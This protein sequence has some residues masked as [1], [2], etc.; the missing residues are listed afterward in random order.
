ML[1]QLE[2]YGELQH[3]TVR[4]TKIDKVIFRMIK[5]S[6]I[7]WKDHCPLKMRLHKL[8]V[9][10]K[11]IGAYASATGSEHSSSDPSKEIPPGTLQDCA[12]I[13]IRL[14]H[15]LLATFSL[16]LEWFATSKLVSSWKGAEGSEINADLT[17]VELAQLYQ[18]AAELEIPTLISLVADTLLM[19]PIYK[20]MMKDLIEYIISQTTPNSDLRKLL[21][22]AVAG[23]ATSEAF[24]QAVNEDWMSKEILSELTLALVQERGGRPRKWKGGHLI[25]EEAVEA[26]QEF[27]I[28]EEKKEEMC[29]PAPAS[30]KRSASMGADGPT[31]KKRKA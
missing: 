28:H 10:Y 21:V 9:L 14:P 11:T 24:K 22:R 8:L 17:V 23:N 16:L 5:S 13:V 27:H 12:Q 6:H 4:K 30:K 1:Q 25:S 2:S 20:S 26:R 18:L 7:S 15:T 29:G 3:T 19:H 31:R